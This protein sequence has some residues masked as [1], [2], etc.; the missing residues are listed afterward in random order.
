MPGTPAVA[1][2][3]PLGKRARRPTTRTGGEDTL[4]NGEA[5]ARGRP[6]RGVTPAARPPRA[7]PGAWG[8][9]P[10]LGRHPGPNEESPAQHAAGPR[11][12]G[13]AGGRSRQSSWRLLLFPGPPELTGSRRG[14]QSTQ[15]RPW[16]RAGA[17]GP[18][19]P[20]PRLC[21]PTPTS[22]A[23]SLAGLLLSACSAR[24]GAQGART[25]S[26]LL[27]VGPKQVPLVYP[28]HTRL[29]LPCSGEQ[30]RRTGPRRP[31]LCLR[32]ATKRM[33]VP[34]AGPCGRTAGCRLQSSRIRSPQEGG[35]A[36]GTLQ[37]QS[38]ATGTV[39]D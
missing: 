15:G 35:L 16:G 7:P 33:V 34:A 8:Q 1:P 22:A 21:V 36:L 14:R 30:V 23:A 3:V 31:G 24:P 28:R 37:G 32:P 2:K 10:G 12:G 4:R 39:V 19:P 5:P 20:A 6:A 26:R 9:G 18:A 25:R 38:S 27:P 17:R 11:A 13:R 29:R